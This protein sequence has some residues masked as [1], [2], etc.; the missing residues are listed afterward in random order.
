MDTRSSE[1]NGSKVVHTGPGLT[2][3]H[4]ILFPSL[5]T[6]GFLQ[7]STRVFRDIS[8]P[9]LCPTGL[10]N[11]ALLRLFPTDNTIQMKH[12]LHDPGP[13]CYSLRLLTLFSSSTQQLLR[14]PAPTYRWLTVPFHMSLRP[15]KCLDLVFLKIQQ[16]TAYLGKLF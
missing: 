16:S 11:V 13:S 3:P 1:R 2:P 10:P 15:A 6:Q 12:L 8:P 14:C 7:S 9:S 5:S 4:P